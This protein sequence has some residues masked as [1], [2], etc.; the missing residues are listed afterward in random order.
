MLSGRNTTISSSDLRSRR[1]GSSPWYTRFIA[2][3]S[4]MK[5]WIT[6]HWPPRGDAPST[7]VPYGVWVQDKKEHLINRVSPGD[8]VFIYETRKG[9]TKVRN[10][11][12]GSTQEIACRRGREGIVALV[13]VIGP[14]ERLNDSVEEHYTNGSK[15]WWRY[16][17][18]TQPV[19]SAGFIPRE[20]VN[21]ALGYARN[22]VFRG[23]GDEHSGLKEVTPAVF[24]DLLQL[25]TASSKE[26]DR[27]EIIR[28]SGSRYGGGG[29]RSC[30]PRVERPYCC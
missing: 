17:A 1:D 6:T 25:F 20:L 13:E 10:F 30:T 24:N 26:H 8:P 12:D 3:I 23:F 4:R 9:R 28:Y 11:A 2:I 22:N 21:S 15:A 5:Y 7:Y 16:C 29:G 14:A 27:K 18:P 19:N